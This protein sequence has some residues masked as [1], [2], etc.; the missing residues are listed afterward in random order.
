MTTTASLSWHEANQRHLTAALAI[1][2]QVLQR[3]AA[4][5]EAQP[6]EPASAQQG[7]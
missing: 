2:R 7:A 6:G 3:H 1:L 4:R 5:V